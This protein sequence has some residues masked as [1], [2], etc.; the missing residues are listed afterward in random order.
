VGFFVMMQAIR[1][2]AGSVIVKILFGLLII[3]FGFWGIADYLHERTSPETVVATVGDEKI[4]ANELQEELQPVVERMRAQ[5][6]GTLDA[7][8]LKQFGVVDALLG[9]L[10]DRKLLYQ[11]VR[12]L[13]LEVP[14]EVIRGAI[15]DNPQ[16]RGPDGRFDRQLFA[17]LLMMRRLT[18]DQ[19]VAKLRRDVPST[20]LLQAITAGVAAPKP[21]VEA[22]YRHRN[23]K[24]IADIV[25][26]PVSAVADVG[27]PSEEQLTKFYES[28]P[29]LFQAPE[30]R[31]FTLASLSPADVK[32][33]A[34]IPDDKLRR[35]YEERKDD[36]ETPEQRQ[37]QQILSPTEEKAKEVEAALQAGKDWQE[38]ATGLAAQDPETMDLGLLS[39]KEIPR[40]L[41]DVAFELPL[42]RP[43][44]PIKTPFGWH[45][46][47]VVKIE[48]RATPSFEEAKPKLIAELQLQ[49]AIDRLAK[50]GNQADD[51]LAAGGK[52]EEIAPKFG[53][54]LTTV[55]AVDEGG[56]DPEGKR[57]DLPVPAEE[58][59][60]AAFST[61]RGETSR[62]ADMQDGS[63]YA[64]RVDK[65]TAPRTKPLDEVKALATAGWQA[66]QKRERTAKEAEALAAAAG[67]DKPL[68]KAAADK[69]LTLMPAVSLSRSP[70]QGQTVPP[71]LITKL[72]AA[73]PGDV[74]TLGDAS[75]G[76]T[77]QLKE[78][79]VPETAPEAEAARLAQQLAGELK[80]D[81]AGEYTGA[82]RKRY[83]VDIKRQ[84]LD[85]LF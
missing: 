29:D 47:R 39:R 53:L 69:G 18:E 50:M 38:V 11:E 82:L 14:D 49:D 57:V 13:G 52:I 85:K 67:P 70:Q 78:V 6:G 24:R 19:L 1:G 51:A 56:N 17:Q 62:I 10:I 68:A 79:Q 66:E 71:A 73:K 55:A 2:R 81:I 33:T 7:Q 83:P 9:Q 27:Q 26:F 58:V 34:D 54:K 45:V 80:L 72:F 15:Y 8:Q 23:E 35:E 22:L 37:I 30:Y 44:Q 60:K 46:L 36:Y 5:F 64:V 59:L 63:I 40:E 75:G 4:R 43:S 28:Y 25:S 20:D 61:S 76:Y 31:A 41:G 16:F 21:V 84:E 12:R 74:V 32:S 3:S 77:A 42:N 65:V 48:P